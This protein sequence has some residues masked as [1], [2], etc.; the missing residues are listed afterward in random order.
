MART[1][2]IRTLGVA[3]GIVAAGSIMAATTGI[4][5]KQARTAAPVAVTHGATA[6]EGSSIAFSRADHVH[7]TSGIAPATSGTAILKGNGAG[8]F[9]S[10][11]PGT[12]YPAV[13]HAHGGGEITSAVANATNAALA[14]RVKSDDTRSVADTPGGFNPGAEFDFKS[15]ATDGLADGGT[16]HG[17][18]TFRPYGSAADFSGGPLHQLGFTAGGNVHLRQGTDG[19]T[20]SAWRKVWHDGNDGS[21]SGLDADKLD[22]LEPGALSVS[23]A[24]TAASAADL[25]CAGACVDLATEVS[26]EMP[27]GQLEGG[28]PGQMEIGKVL[29][30]LPS[31]PF[32]S[33]VGWEYPAPAPLPTSSGYDLTFIGPNPP[34]ANTHPPSPAVGWVASRRDGSGTLFSSTAR[35]FYDADAS[36]TFYWN[37]EKD[38]TTV[39]SIREDGVF[40]GTATRAFDANS[41]PWSGITERPTNFT[42]PAADVDTTGGIRL[43]GDLTGSFTSPQVVDDSHSHTSATVSSATNATNATASQTIAFWDGTGRMTPVHGIASLG[44]RTVPMAPS[45]FQKGLFAQF[46]QTSGFGIPSG[47]YYSGLLTVAP[48]SS[49]V[50]STGGQ[51]YQLAFTGDNVGGVS[52]PELRLRAGIDSTWGAWSRFWHEGNDGAGSGLAADTLDGIDSATFSQTSHTHSGSTI[53]G[54]DAADVTTG[55]F[56]GARLGTYDLAAF[57][58]GKPTASVVLARLAVTRPTRLPASLSGSVFYSGANATSSAAVTLRKR[59]AA[60]VTTSI[61][62]LTWS[63]ASATPSVSF[64]STVDFVAGDFLEFFSPS[65]TD[66]TLAD[67]SITLVATKL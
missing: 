21:G 10:A 24:T 5:T 26:G 56:A 33:V 12:D 48:Y 65:N 17:V 42:P 47:H 1:T 46:V 32:E 9:S 8:G 7:S 53:S 14:T 60:G 51:A 62:Y 40:S 23:H 18:F 35:L 2:V 37:F 66:A 59:T 67:L 44:S 3:L 61:G 41:V 43:T 22:G 50:A 49:T 57:L 45:Q 64:T 58:P 28:G 20:W 54:L 11:V 27:V 29:T 39:A 19:T 38:G 36:A 15:N 52:P 13:G 6:A 31:G 16:Y 55:V 25:V 34:G 63:S 30:I 4:T